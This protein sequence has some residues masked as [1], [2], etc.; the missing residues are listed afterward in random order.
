VKTLLVKA[1]SSIRCLLAPLDD[2]TGTSSSAGT[3]VLG[4]TTRILKELARS[5]ARTSG[6]HILNNILIASLHLSHLLAVSS[7]FRSN[8]LADQTRHVFIQGHADLP[9]SFSSNDLDSAGLAESEKIHL[10]SLLTND[11]SSYKLRLPL[12]FA[13]FLSP[14]AL[15]RTKSIWK[16]SLNRCHLLKVCPLYK[17]I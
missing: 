9:E 10:L 5:M 8:V 15:L 14:L 4:P 17:P 6:C 12:L 3:T 16:L 11:D 1:R 13:L 2:L 7:R